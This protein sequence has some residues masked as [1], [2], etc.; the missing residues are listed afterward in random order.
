MERGEGLGLIM[1]VSQF[2]VRWQIQKETAQYLYTLS[3]ALNK[4]V[5]FFEEWG[6]V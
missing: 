1:M 3:N 6:L 5:L 4:S 2:G